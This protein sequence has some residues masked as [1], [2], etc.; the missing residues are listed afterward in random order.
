MSAI[1]AQALVLLSAFVDECATAINPA[2]IPRNQRS[3]F[4]RLIGFDAL[5]RSPCGVRIALCPYCEETPLQLGNESVQRCPNCGPIIISANDLLRV[6]PNLDWL[7]KRLAQALTI[8]RSVIP[9]EILKKHAWFVGDIGYGSSLRRVIFARN[10]TSPIVMKNLLQEMPKHTGTSAV[11]IISTTEPSL[12]MPALRAEILYLPHAFRLHGGALVADAPILDGVL[13]A[14]LTDQTASAMDGPFIDDFSRVLLDGEKAAIPLTKLQGT[15]FR[16]LWRL[17]GKRIDGEK[18]MRKCN[19][20]G[21]PS[22]AFKPS[23]YPHA[24]RAYKLLVKSDRP[25]G[26]YWMPR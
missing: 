4:D 20:E 6:E 24:N 1:N 25:K 5:K 11:V 12:M 7:L 18:L 19:G 9:R 3:A 14:P 15:I 22:D 8:S 10:L 26:E 21:K 23:K 2:L 17:N 16:E 13:S